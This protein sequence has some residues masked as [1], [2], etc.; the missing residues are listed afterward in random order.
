MKEFFT[1]Y[2]L[3]NTCG[4]ESYGRLFYGQ[5]SYGHLSYGHLSYGHLSYCRTDARRT[6][7]RRTDVTLSITRRSLSQAVLLNVREIMELAMSTSIPDSINGFACFDY[8][9]RVSS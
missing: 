8:E 4:Q 3:E 6:D 1:T 2:A 5:L 7:A 9:V